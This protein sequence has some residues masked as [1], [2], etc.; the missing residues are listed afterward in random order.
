MRGAAGSGD[1]WS[2]RAA[3]ILAAIGSAVGLG[4]LW[5][6]PYVAGENGGGAFVLFYVVC[7]LLIGLPVLVAELF[8]GRR[9]GM[10][11]VGSVVK[12]AKAE[13][14]SPLWALQSWIGMIAS[15]VILTFY[16]VIAGWVI[17]YVVMIAGDLFASV[18]EQGLAGLGAG[19]FNGQSQDDINAKLG[20]LLNDPKRMILYH[21]LFMALTAAIV[22]RGVISGIEATVTVLMPAFFVLLIILLGFSLV[23]GDAIAGADFLLG[24]RL[25]DLWAGAK[26]G[27]VISAALGQ[28]FFSIGLG[29]A[30]MATYGAYM[31]TDQ[32]LPNSARIVALAD[33]GVGI[34][35]GLAIFPIVFA[36]SLSAGA[37]PQL[38]FLTLPLAFN[39]MPAG[40]VFG[41]AFFILALFA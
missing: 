30:L 12:I 22:A 24:M 2:S 17:A 41:L 27:S 1:H 40:G 14:R 8:I 6:F 31:R 38:I 20:D 3:F 33:T 39:G 35:A 19:A 37:G 25:E 23:E 13:G 29:S 36:M 32:D 28:A 10:S 34:I 21:A 7:V 5:R 4:N 26:N 16:S 9:G 15:F 18:G 11:A